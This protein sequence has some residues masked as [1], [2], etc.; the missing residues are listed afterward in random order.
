MTFAFNIPGKS[1]LEDKYLCKTVL[2]G[3]NLQLKFH[4]SVA[5]SLPQATFFSGGVL[6]V[7]QIR[8]G[9]RKPDQA[10]LLGLI[11]P[12]CCTTAGRTLFQNRQIG[13]EKCTTTPSL[14]FCLDSVGSTGS[15]AK[16][17]PA[18]VSRAT[19]SRKLLHDPRNTEG[20]PLLCRVSGDSSA[21]LPGLGA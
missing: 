5:L 15:L 3:K 14:V 16:S 20:P 8:A 7:V 9:F 1:K 19:L 10:R 4:L 12:G 21:P 6:W 17:R 13:S 11:G 2:E 18:Q